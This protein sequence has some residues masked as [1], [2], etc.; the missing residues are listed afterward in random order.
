M[1]IKSRNLFFKS[2]PGNNRDVNRMNR[3]I[4][5]QFPGNSTT[6][7]SADF[8]EPGEDE[9]GDAETYPQE[10]LHRLEP[11]GLSVHELELKVGAP[12]ARAF[13][14]EKSSKTHLH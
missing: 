7:Y 13:C 9:D 10:F 12:V 8:F 2:L 5:N 11:H 3:K 14:D 1:L 4:L 6:Y